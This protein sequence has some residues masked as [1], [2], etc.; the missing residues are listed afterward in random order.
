MSHRLP[1]ILRFVCLLSLLT[2]FVPAVLTAQVM[3][4]PTTVRN[5]VHHDVSLPLSVMAK[6]PPKDTEE[7]KEAEAWKRV[8]LPPGFSQSTED[9]VIQALDLPTTLSPSVGLSF[10]GLGQGQYGFTVQ[11]APPDTNGAV[12]ATQYVQWVNSKFIVF[13]KVTG[14]KLLGPLAGNTLWSNFGGGCQTNNNGDP[15]VQYDK[16]ANRWVMSQFSVSTLPYLQCVAVSQTSDATGEWY[17]YSFSYGNALFDDYPKMAVWPDAYYETFNMFQNGQTYVGP[18]VCAYDRNKML[19][20]QAATQVCFQKPPTVDPMLAADL[21]GTT[22]PPVGSPNYVVTFGAMRM[23]WT[24][25][26][27]TS[28]L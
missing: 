23:C 17:R 6:N 26:S 7:E 1:G 15:V 14:A 24:S 3:E 5:N 10:E 25:I 19:T 9:P 16:L 27:F 28:T 11:A 21:D 8:P 2:F 4:G 22:P 13:D 12:G 18:D 20:G